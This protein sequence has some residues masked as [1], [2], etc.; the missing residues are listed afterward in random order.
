MPL[1]RAIDGAMPVW[2]NNNCSGEVGEGWEGH[3][4]SEC[5]WMQFWAEL[6]TPAE[7]RAT[8]SSRADQSKSAASSGC[9]T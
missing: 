1:T 4:H 2:G 5:V 7:R 9:R 6:P 3:L 8:G